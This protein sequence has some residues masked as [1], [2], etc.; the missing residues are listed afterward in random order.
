MDSDQLSNAE[1]PKD[2]GFLAATYL[3]LICGLVALFSVSYTAALAS[4]F[5]GAIAGSMG[6]SKRCF[7]A[8]CGIAMCFNGVLFLWG[9]FV[10]LVAVPH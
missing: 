9:F 5:V 6:L 8:A 7:P 10:L 1:A 4:W 2:R 3:L